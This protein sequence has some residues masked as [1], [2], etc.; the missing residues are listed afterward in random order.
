MKPTGI[1]IA[2]ERAQEA[3]S[4]LLQEFL[5]PVVQLHAEVLAIDV[6]PAAG[7]QARQ[8]M[9]YGELDRLSDQVARHLLPRITDETIL[10]LMI[11]RATPL[12]YVAQLAV[13]KAGGAYTCID[14]SFP[15]DRIAEIIADA[16][17]AAILALGDSLAR[18]G[19]LA[20]GSD[21]L[22]DVEAL[23]R[24]RTAPV[25]P[26]PELSPERLAYVIYTSGTTGKPKGVQIEHRNIANLVASD[27][28]EFG[29][30]RNDRVVQ[31]SSSAYDSSIEETWLAFAA[32][33]T[34]VVMGDAA[35]RLGPDLVAWL[36]AER[37][38]VFCPPPTLLRS[39]GCADPARALPDLRLLYVGGEALPADIADRWSQGRRMVNGYGPTECA[40]TCLRGDVVAGEEVGIG[41]P[42]PGMHAWVLDEVLNECSIGQRGEL[43]IGGAGV[44]RGYRQAP[45]LT[46]EKFVEHPLLGRIY[47]TGDL[48]HCNADGGFFYHGRIDAQVKIRGYRVELGEIDARLAALDGVRAGACKLQATRIG[49]ELVGYA[50]AADP[51]SPPDPEQ[52]RTDLRHVLPAY[53]VPVRIA[54][55][56]D[57][58]T[59]IGGKLDRA[60]LPDLDLG[61][62][63]VGA[64][65][66]PPASE[67]EAF[68]AVAVG[69]ILNKPGAVSVDADFFADLGGDSLSAALLVTL[70]RDDPRGQWVTVSDIYE[71]RSVRALAAMAHPIVDA[72]EDEPAELAIP[73][74]GTVR[75]LLANL[76]QIGWLSGELMVGGW[77]AWLLV[78][79]VL[80]VLFQ[81]LSLIGFVVLTP[82]LALAALALYVPVAILFA[83]LVKRIVIGRYRPMRAPVWSGW[84]LRHWIVAQACRLIP[85]PLLQG[86]MLQQ[87]ILRALGARIG[88]RVHIHRG[89]DLSRGGWDLLELGDGVAL[90]QDAEIA[91]VELDRGDIVV[92]P[93]V[94]EAG[95]A[96]ETRAGVSAW[97][98]M[99]RGSVLASLSS[100]N[101]GCE[102]PAGEVW[103]GVPARRVG[104]APL[105]PQPTVASR[106]IQPWL[107]DLAASVAEGALG[108]AATLPG[109]ILT[110]LACWMTDTGIEEIWRWTYHPSVES[111]AGML[112]VALTIASVPL[113]LVWSAVLMRV[114][115]RVAPG[116]YPRW[117]LGYLR[118]W[119]KAGI[120]RLSGEW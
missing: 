17:P 114:M 57:L 62:D 18:L 98:R 89:V 59:T 69:D 107:F 77:L 80:P 37:I 21:L 97:C 26:L 7:R 5:Q 84:Y 111:R 83:V 100:L 50:V 85:W 51:L 10:A 108:F 93:I 90:G 53:M 16:E 29:L 88:Q 73:R 23:V 116:V 104:I 70:L 79:R 54:L 27:I 72:G 96:L 115:G 78:F 22:L 95:V 4:Q 86:T 92:G 36:R 25:L 75:P 99:G 15:D 94:L 64:T 2:Q 74:T 55:V 87:T 109:M 32:G 31:G 34:L 82:V 71:A 44:A 63:D 35:A 76:V 28:A 45:E 112:V 61:R 68:I 101:S 13:L 118:A 1:D 9:T 48:V 49:S 103:D 117:S 42:V 66:T 102:V 113:T 20:I 19:N 67:M 106:E 91:L 33:A 120:L 43:C 38:T 14:P 81:N 52:L 40:V 6:P 110:V 30:G 46:A 47:R 39:S 3:G 60:R 65:E 11:P 119:L 41:R 105:P 58:P 56:S 12:L 24:D 8:T